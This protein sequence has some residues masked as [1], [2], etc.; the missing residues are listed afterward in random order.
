MILKLK[1]LD[2]SIG[3]TG[4]SWDRVRLSNMPH[5][6]LVVQKILIDDEHQRTTEQ[7]RTALVK[8]KCQNS[9]DNS[10]P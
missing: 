3:R 9:L 5:L 10:L 1:L 2:R 7:N 6:S 4:F 8:E